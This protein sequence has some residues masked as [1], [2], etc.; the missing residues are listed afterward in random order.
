M[1]GATNMLQSGIAIGFG[2]FP[3]LFSFSQIAFN[4]LYAARERIEINVSKQDLVACGRSHLRNSVAHSACAYDAYC[5]NRGP[6]SGSPAGVVVGLRSD[7]RFQSFSQ[8]P[9]S[10]LSSV[11]PLLKPTTTDR[12]STR[13]NSITSLSRMPSSA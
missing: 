2:K 6:Q 3:E 10:R 9:K 12:K 5:F 8:V 1:R 7:A 13:L 4:R 11:R